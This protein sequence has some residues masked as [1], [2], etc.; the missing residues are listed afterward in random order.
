[1]E[2]IP[3]EG[4]ENEYL[5]FFRDESRSTGHA[6]SISFPENENDL[7]DHLRYLYSKDIKVTIQGARTGISGGAVPHGGHIISLT[8]M[9]KILTDPGKGF[10]RL[11]VQPGV[12]L[13]DLPGDKGW[14]F[15]PDPTETTASF[16]GIAA[17]NSSGSRSYKYGAARNYIDTLRIVLS[18]GNVI[19]LER[20][21][22]KAAGRFFDIISENS[23][24]F[25]GIL[26][27]YRMPDTKNASGYYSKKD[28]D[29]IDLFIGSEGTL[30]VISEIGLKL[31][32]RPLFQ[33]GILLLFSDEESSIEYVSAIR[34]N[35]FIKPAAI[36]FFDAAALSL[37][38]AHLPPGDHK[39]AIYVEADSSSEDELT[40][41]ILE[42]AALAGRFGCKENDNIFAE[43]P[44][45][46]QILK[47]MRHLIPEKV[48][49]MVD[50][51][52][53]DCPRITKLGTDMAVPDDRLK[54]T[55]R[56]YRYDLEKLGYKAVLFGH[57]GNNHVHVNIIPRNA[58]EYS[59]AGKLHEKWIKYVI[60]AGGSVSAEHGIGKLKKP[61]LEAMYGI[62]GI[63]EMR[64][65]K[66]IFDPKDILNSGNLF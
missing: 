23:S 58:E 51:I 61:F 16:G 29:L 44:E 33:W 24:R 32:P 7:R 55:M 66:K 19:F 4:K 65:V 40:E 13:R 46:M 53:K 28:M 20:G 1:M 38:K 43:T 57:I 45:H 36:E 35:N 39:A 9:N 10:G 62:D 52:R 50:E 34:R 49:M 12:V 17:C 60:G 42:A 63:N 37:I 25:S 27:A 18:D 48:N 11:I 26:P 59:R 41:R 14:F 31:I 3:L 8:R 54:E 47:D 56:M 2:M 6:D 5:D 21:V 22:Q 30:G 15:P 64:A